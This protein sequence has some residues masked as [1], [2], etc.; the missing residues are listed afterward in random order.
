MTE[1]EKH[2][3]KIAM[4][5]LNDK[6]YEFFRD[7]RNEDL[8]QNTLNYILN[9][10]KALEMTENEKR[11]E[12]QCLEQEAEDLVNGDYSDLAIFCRESVSN[13]YKVG[14]HNGREASCYFDQIFKLIGGE[15]QKAYVAERAKIKE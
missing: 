10:S 11:I 13:A 2:L 12:L 3:R 9:Q 6:A 15:P 5:L 8:E 1:Q 7:R 4:S 14:K